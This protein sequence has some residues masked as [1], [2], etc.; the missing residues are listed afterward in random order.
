MRNTSRTLRR[1]AAIAVA[2]A[3]GLS[4]A[5]PAATAGPQA[6]KGAGK[7]DVPSI[8]TK[9]AVAKGQYQTAYSERNDVLWAASAVGRPP[10]TQTALLKLDPDT[11]EVIDTITP[12]LVNETTGA[13][14]AV[15]GVEVDDENNTV[16]VTNTRDN[17]VA[18]YSQRTGEHLAFIPNVSH[19]REVVIDTRRDT[20]WVS[21][22]NSAE[23]VAF[24]TDTFEEKR[25]VTVEGSRPAGLALEERSGKVYASDLN[26]DQII[27]ISPYKETVELHPAG[28]GAISVSL[29][30]NGRTAYTANQTDGTVTVTDL[31]TSTV[32]A[33]IPTG[34]GALSVR[35]DFRTGKLVVANRVAATVSIVDPK[36]GTVQNLVTEANP[37]H[38]EIEDGIAYVVDKSGANAEGGDFAYR[39][40][41]GH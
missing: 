19:A 3:A 24:D 37:N 29:S 6:G 15:Y 34:E 40:D 4:L 7:H 16:W 38:V 9:T 33:T 23:V 21:A 12:P 32:T 39:I 2:A 22:V 31:R 8:A 11:L 20:A 26:G 25:R 41:L 18:V 5:V 30:K 17:G 27:E 14:E 36:R 1:A 35:T 28:A 13:R 10:V